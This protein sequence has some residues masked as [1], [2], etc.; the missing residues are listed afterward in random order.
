MKLWTISNRLRKTRDFRQALLQRL[1]LFSLMTGEA[2]FS[3]DIHTWTLFTISTSHY[4]RKGIHVLKVYILIFMKFSLMQTSFSWGGESKVYNKQSITWIS[5]YV[6]FKLFFEVLD[7]WRKSILH[8]DHNQ[9]ISQIPKQNWFLHYVTEKMD[10][11]WC[12]H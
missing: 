3:I 10:L 8:G 6:I 1:L 2:F 11:V 5:F 12:Q 7:F 9:N 4:L